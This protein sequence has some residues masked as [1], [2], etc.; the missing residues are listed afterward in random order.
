MMHGEEIRR[1]SGQYRLE[2]SNFNLKSVYRMSGR[3][4]FI[5]FPLLRFFTTPVNYL[6]HVVAMD[7]L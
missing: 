2:M 1:N 4:L 3:A 5:L 6:S 7:I